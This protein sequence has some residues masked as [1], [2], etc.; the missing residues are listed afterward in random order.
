MLMSKQDESVWRMR[1]RAT[2]VI[3]CQRFWENEWDIGIVL[4]V[5]CRK[6]C[7]L[8]RLSYMF[9]AERLQAIDLYL[10]F[11]GGYIHGN[12]YENL[13]IVLIYQIIVLYSAFKGM[14]LGVGARGAVGMWRR[15]R[16]SR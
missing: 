16:A 2:F 8:D 3:K 14:D 10:I 15:T 13:M 6:C 11:R 12:V 4:R 9:L 5:R 7:Q 1:W